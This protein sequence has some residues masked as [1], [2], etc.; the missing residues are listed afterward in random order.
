MSSLSD[1]CSPCT[2]QIA[3]LSIPGPQGATGPAGTNGTNGTSAISITT[4]TVGP[5][6]A[7]TTTT[8][9]VSVASSIMFTV[10]E[11]LILGQ[12]P[13]VALTNPGPLAVVITAIP[14]V[15]NLTVKNLRTVD[16]GVT[17][18]SGAQ[19]TPIGFQGTSVT[20]PTTTKGDI[21][22]DDGASSPNPHVVRLAVG[23][24]GRAPIAKSSATTG[25]AYAGVSQTQNVNTTGVG[26]G[27]D[28]TEDDLMTF[29]VVGG[30]LANN[31]DMIEFECVFDCAAN[32]DNKTIKV[33]FGATTILTMGPVAQNGGSVVI[34][35]RV[36]RTGAATQRCYAWMQNT[37]AAGTSA[38]SVADV[39][40]AENLAGAVTFKATGQAGVANANDILQQVMVVN[41]R[42]A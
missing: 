27:A 17:V 29:S 41:Y 15:N 16:Q 38:T 32:A 12:G 34:N 37:N 19:V 26:N 40:A 6:P 2:T 18:S 20:F 23:N 35:G 10:G 22:V 13:G 31:G 33:K 39:T 25:I 1:C 5:T 3:P 30:T 42:A 9:N 8:Y 7:D 21:I 24:N 14:S 36:I 4:A 28:V 11:N